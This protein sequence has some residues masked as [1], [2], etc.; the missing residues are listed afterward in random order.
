[1]YSNFKAEYARK[2]FTLEK[3][4]E[5]MEKRGCKRTMTTLSQKLNGKYTLTL[6]EAKVLQEIV[7]PE[8]PLEILFETKV[9]EAS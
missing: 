1:M 8:I 9:E 4:V 6:N 2:G 3:L 5:E 7:A